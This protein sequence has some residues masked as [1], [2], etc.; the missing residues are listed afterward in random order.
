M[1]KAKCNFLAFGVE[2][3]TQKILDRS[4]SAD[5]GA[6][7]HAVSEAKRHGI[8]RAHGFFLVGSPVKR[9]RTSWRVF[10]CGPVEAGHVWV[11]PIVRLPGHA[12]W[13]EY[14]ERGLLDDERDWH[15][16]FKCSDIDPTV[17][18]A[19]L[20]I[21]P[22]ER[23]RDPFRPPPLVR[24]LQTFK[25]LRTLS[26]HMRWLDIFKLLSSPFRRRALNRM[27]E[28]PARMIELGLT[29]PIRPALPP[30]RRHRHRQ[31]HSRPRRAPRAAAR[32]R[33]PSVE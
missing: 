20:S 1:S 14:L 26:R 11:Q 25:L 5:A 28:L 30:S 10:V 12:L 6:N 22:P 31:R 7:R 19:R 3:G 33:R 21:A 16:W 15:K 27:P 23:L 32:S 17:L 2:A 4:T 8:E 24:P 29:A 9:K 13:K 18:P